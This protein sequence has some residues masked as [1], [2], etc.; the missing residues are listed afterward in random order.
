M[1]EENLFALEGKSFLPGMK[2]F[3]SS[4]KRSHIPECKKTNLLTD[5]TL[6]IHE[7]LSLPGRLWI[8]TGNVVQGDLKPCR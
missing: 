6:C 8:S 3:P 7:K 1:A 4:Q 5:E 2:S